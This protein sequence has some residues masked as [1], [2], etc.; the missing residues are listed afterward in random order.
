M[1]ALTL[2]RVSASFGDQRVLD[3]VSATLPAGGLIAVLGPNGAGKSTLL[4]AIAG[5]HLIEGNIQFAGRSLADCTRNERARLI[6]YLPQGHET[7][8][9]L[10][11]GEI[12]GLGRFP[13]GATD[14]RQLSGADADAVRRAM[15]ATD[16]ARFAHRRATE[17]SGGERAR[18]ALARVLAQE[19]PVI[20]A[21][22]P[23]ASLDPRFQIEVLTTLASIAR[24][25]RNVLAV[26]HNLDLAHRFADHALVLDAGRIAANGPIGAAL[27]EALCART[28]GIRRAKPGG[29]TL[30]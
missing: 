15:E 22:E 26:L 4:R 7:H 24:S 18:V 30:A 1:T 10:S 9:P 6:G 19:T 13:H 21:D 27:T 12:V 14:P 2:D 29:W 16:V 28:F 20:L 17:L 11:V 25:G 23:T 5:L 8:W 3:A